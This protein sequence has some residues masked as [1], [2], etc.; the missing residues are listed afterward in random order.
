MSRTSHLFLK[1]SAVALLSISLGANVT[2]APKQVKTTM[3]AV[4]VVKQ[5]HALL[6]CATGEVPTGGWTNP[7][8]TP[9]DYIVPPKDGIFEVDFTAEPPKPGTQ[10]TQQFTPIKKQYFWS[11]YP[12]KELKGVNVNGVIA[13][14]VARPTFCNISKK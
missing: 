14:L 7:T 9:R 10:V 11:P 4:E 8:L 3:A 12:E 1:S 13:K 2:A 6:V 5:P